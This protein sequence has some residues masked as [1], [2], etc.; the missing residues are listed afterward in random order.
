MTEDFF[1]RAL[2]TIADC[3]AKSVIILC[4][5][6][7]ITLSIRRSAAMRHL[8]WQTA[9]AVLL[10]LPLLSGF[11]PSLG[12]A[13][14]VTGAQA[15]EK[16]SPTPDT[17]AAQESLT[18]PFAGPRETESVQIESPRHEKPVG[19][20]RFS[21]NLKPYLIR[22]VI[23]LWLSGVV[24]IIFRSLFAYLAVVKLRRRSMLGTPQRIDLAAISSRA[25]L[26]SKWELRTS[27]QARP[28]SAMTWG[29]FQPVVLLPQCSADWSA[30]WLEAV[31]LHELAHVRRRD[32]ASQM[33]I[34]TVCA[35]YWFNPFVWICARAVRAE[36]ERAADDLVLHCGVSSSAY[37]TELLRLAAMQ[38]GHQQP[39]LIAGHGLSMM[40][41]SR[42]EARIRSIV[43]P[44]CRR[45]GAS[46]AESTAVIVVGLLTLLLFVPYR[47][48]GFAASLRDTLPLTKE[49]MMGEERPS[50]KTDNPNNEQQILPALL[51]L[52]AKEQVTGEDEEL[53]V[54]TSALR[55]VAGRADLHRR[56]EFPV[57]VLVTSL[58]YFSVSE[59]TQWS[60]DQKTTRGQA[61]D[62]ISGSADRSQKAVASGSDVVA[63]RN[64][65]DG[66]PVEILS[67]AD[68][69]AGK[70]ERSISEGRGADLLPV[71]SPFRTEENR[72]HPR[73]RRDAVSPDLLPNGSQPPSA[74][75]GGAGARPRAPD[76]RSPSP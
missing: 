45:R 55:T 8:V 49:A 1:T 38:A 61:A 68:A 32:S 5:A 73:R 25:G 47:S 56:H 51:S 63:D 12:V 58:E 28:A 50:K 3:G 22:G 14:L 40:N 11:V 20:S 16:G 7:L 76:V 34:E 44:H 66:P 41:G 23:A 36:T 35:I 9:F 39:Q 67:H 18:S 46:S 64:V 24:L 27:V 4:G 2:V 60:A 70:S 52:T 43:E 71:N 30:G 19:L 59:P 65:E 75:R 53:K 48:V 10:L 62:Q 72:R 37:A 17:L 54:T 31:L 69:D 26:R 74:E 21:R 29:L 6:W 15:L 57:P 13:Y 33:L 42:I